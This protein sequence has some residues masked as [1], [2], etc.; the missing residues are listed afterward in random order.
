MIAANPIVIAI[1]SAITYHRTRP[2]ACGVRATCPTSMP[3]A[4]TPLTAPSMSVR[5][6]QAAPVDTSPTIRAMPLITP[7]TTTRSSAARIIL[8]PAM[9][10]TNTA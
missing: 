9:N 6:A 2:A 10:A 8:K 4:P 3:I 1:I 7:S 5:S